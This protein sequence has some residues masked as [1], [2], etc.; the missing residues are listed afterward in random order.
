[1]YLDLNNYCNINIYDKTHI[2]FNGNGTCKRRKSCQEVMVR[3][4]VLIQTV[5]LKKTRLRDTTNPSNSKQILIKRSM[6]HIAHLRKQFKSI[7]I[8]LIKGRKTNYL[9]Y[10]N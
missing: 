9:L 5:L 6:S 3:C 7:I 4:Q 8:M 10:K 2:P 1:M